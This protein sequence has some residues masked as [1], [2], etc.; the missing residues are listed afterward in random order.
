MPIHVPPGLRRIQDAEFNRVAYE[1]MEIIFKV[2]NEMGR[3]FDEPVYQRAIAHRLNDALIEAPLR[4]SFNG[5]EKTYYLDL[6]VH[7]GALFE[8]KAAEATHD[9]HRAQTLNYLLLLEL[10]HGKLV[11]F[12]NALVEH[13]FVNAPLTRE[14]R[15]RFEVEDAAYVKMQN[16]GLDLRE[17]FVPILRD[18]GT[19]LDL[20]LYEEAL[21]HFF[22]GENQVVR[23][24]E[25]FDGELKVGAQTLPLISSDTA[26]RITA[27][28]RDFDEFEDHLRRFLHHT[29]LRAIQWVNVRNQLVA[30]R[31]LIRT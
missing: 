8:L 29:K 9:R 21:V 15:I 16:G 22:G 11:N 31:T 30:F 3:L 18:W 13:E 20:K 12:R 6:L 17:L 26:L 1:V 4:I 14:D 25:I 7:S 24:V 23:P 28:S 5:F 19:G 2:H 27:L 10:P